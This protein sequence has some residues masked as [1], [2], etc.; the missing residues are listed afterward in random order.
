L[1]TKPPAD[2]SNITT[3]QTTQMTSANVQIALRAM[4]YNVVK[5]TDSQMIAGVKTFLEVP[6][7]GTRASGDNSTR[8]QYGLL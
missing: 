8:C 2:E 3:L 6:V 1:Q 4:D 5:L 7:T